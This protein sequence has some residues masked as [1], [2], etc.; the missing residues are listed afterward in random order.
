VEEVVEEE[1]AG[2]VGA[3]MLLLLLVEVKLLPNGAL[4]KGSEEE[5]SL[6][7][8]EVSTAVVVEVAVAVVVELVVV[9][10]ELKEG[11]KGF[12]ELSAGSWGGC[13]C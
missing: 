6:V 4:A 1:E 13:C 10:L 2:G 5:E 7:L 12:H 11:S 9:L 3:E 8:F